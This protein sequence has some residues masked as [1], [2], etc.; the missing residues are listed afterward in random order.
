MTL[1]MSTVATGTITM[2]VT[3]QNPRLTIM[4]MIGIKYV[5]IIPAYAFRFRKKFSL[6]LPYCCSLGVKLFHSV[7]AFPGQII[8][9]LLFNTAMKKCNIF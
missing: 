4:Q 5:C 6:N 3:N 7:I 8:K 9:S 2:I 1:M